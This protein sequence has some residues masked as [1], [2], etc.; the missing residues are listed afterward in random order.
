MRTFMPRH[1]CFTVLAILLLGMGLQA[2]PVQAATLPT[3]PA[4]VG[5]W[6]QVFLDSFAGNTLSSVWQNCTTWS[7]S[8]DMGNPFLT[9]NEVV[10]GGYL[11]LL[12]THNNGSYQASLIRS[13]GFAFTYGYVEARLQIPAGQGF[14]PAFWLLDNV[15][16][17][18]NQ[19]EIDVVELLGQTPHVA[20]LTVHAGNL[21]QGTAFTGPDFSA[22]FHT[23]GVDWEPTF[24]KWYI[25]GVVRQTVT[26]AAYLKHTPMYLLL[27]LAVGGSWPGPPNAST[28]FP[29]QVTVDYVA[30]WQHGPATSPTPIVPT[31]TR[32]VP[33]ATAVTTTATTVPTAAFVCAG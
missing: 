25:D 15:A 5:Q 16:S 22:G 8:D 26:N 12:A 7:C 19:S 14:W 30:V 21:Q 28:P 31:P 1:V 24:I 10:S 32:T 27:N 2:Q 13:A 20:Y 3:T 29:S 9:S 4:I 17:G 33:T 23:F 18:P 6:R 11:H